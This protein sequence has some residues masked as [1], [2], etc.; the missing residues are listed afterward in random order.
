MVFYCHIGEINLQKM[1]I[2]NTRV[3]IEIVYE[4]VNYDISI[5]LRWC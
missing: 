2:R 4:N 3:I 5:I 1:L